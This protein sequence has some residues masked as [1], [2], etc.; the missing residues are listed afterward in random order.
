MMFLQNSGT[1]SYRSVGLISA[2]PAEVSALAWKEFY[3]SLWIPYHEP[4]TDSEI[5]FNLCPC[6]HWAY[7]MPDIV[8]AKPCS[9]EVPHL[10][11]KTQEVGR[12]PV[13]LILARMVRDY[14]LNAY[15]KAN[16]GCTWM[17]RNTKAPVSQGFGLHLRCFFSIWNSIWLIAGVT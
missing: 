4:G 11:H 12:V 5:A 17:P 13:F 8:L 9:T 6:V 10:S 14:A 2:G 1:S 7:N 16:P 15:R 3:L